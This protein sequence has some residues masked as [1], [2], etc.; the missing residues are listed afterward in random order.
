MD[1]VKPLETPC[2]EGCVP[3]WAEDDWAPWSKCE[4]SKAERTRDNKGGACTSYDSADK[5]K[6]KVV[7]DAPRKESDC[8]KTKP[9]RRQKKSKKDCT[10][11]EWKEGG[12]KYEWKPTTWNAWTIPEAC[13]PVNRTRTRNSECVRV[14]NCTA[15]DPKKPSNE[16]QVTEEDCSTGRAGRAAKPEA[17]E[18]KFPDDSSSVDDKGKGVVNF[19][20]CMYS[21]CMGP[22]SDWDDSKKDCKVYNKTRTRT[23]NCCRSDGAAAP[24][25]KCSGDHNATACKSAGMMSSPSWGVVLATTAAVLMAAVGH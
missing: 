7:K 16:V 14:E 8:K 17:G 9:E 11:K 10:Q 24:D 3:D 25:C 6:R 2:D 22:W 23:V 12:A 5:E 19:I 21:W 13:G 20:K 4:C 15:H 18:R 1:G